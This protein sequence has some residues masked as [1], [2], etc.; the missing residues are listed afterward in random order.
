MQKARA[1]VRRSSEELW[2]LAA[3]EPS[4][5]WLKYRMHEDAPQGIFIDAWHEAFGGLL[6]PEAPAKPPAAPIMGAGM[7]QV[8]SF[9]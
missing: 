4:N 2:Q 6:A 1:W 5:F 8:Q 3:M 7:R 9:F